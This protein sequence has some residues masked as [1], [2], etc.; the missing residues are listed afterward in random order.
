MPNLDYG[1]SDR[2]WTAKGVTVSEDSDVAIVGSGPYALSLAAHLRA[3]GVEFRIFGPALKFWRDQAPGG[4]LKT[5][6]ETM[7]LA[8]PERA[9]SFVAWCAHQG[10]GNDP[11][12]MS[13][14]TNYALAMQRTFVPE[15]EPAEVTRVSYA[16]GGA[17]ELTLG[18]GERLTARRVV[19]ATGLAHMA[20]IPDVLSHLPPELLAHTA[21]VRDYTAYR[22]LDVA[23]VGGGASAIE[24]GIAVHE[25]GGCPE[26]LVR[27]DAVTFDERPRAARTSFERLRHPSSVFGYGLRGRALQAAPFAIRFVTASRRARIV[28]SR[29]APSAAWWSE[30]RMADEV[31][32][33]TGTEILAAERHGDRIRL[34]LR[35]PS[36]ECSTE[37]DRIIAGT[38]YTAD[39][40]RLPFLD[41]ELRQRIGRVG[42]APALSS[43]FQSSLESAFFVGP[44]AAESC[45]PVFRFVAGARCAGPALALHLAGPVRAVVSAVRHLGTRGMARGH[46]TALAR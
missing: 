10:E 30:E 13:A 31:P 18:H 39:V 28:A 24:A 22:G 20:S 32:L 9:P 45:G 21:E 46:A 17:L 29:L 7:G 16:G 19:F 35:T 40:D 12:S 5:A 26:V 41:E 44:M 14:F 37:V 27:K 38:G 25:A 2:P 42:R 33:C 6:G 1:Y 3:L 34:Q 43:A 4:F 15:L 8:L 11:R 23:V 36:G